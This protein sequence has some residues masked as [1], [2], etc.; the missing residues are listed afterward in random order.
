M[1]SYI[2]K[3]CQLFSI[4]TLFLL[5]GLF[6]QPA[7]AQCDFI[8]NITGIV[9]GTLPVGD[10]ANPL[11]YTQVYVLVDNQGNIFATNPTPN[12][13]LVPAGFYQL[14]AVNYD[15]AEVLT[16]LPMLAIGQPWFNLEVYGND[17][18]NNCLDYSLPYGS[19]CP[20]VVCDEMTICEVDTLNILALNY[21]TSAHSQTYCLVCNDIVVAMETGGLF[22]LQDYT[23]AAAGANCQ[24]F[25]LNFNTNDGNPISLGSNWTT[26]TDAEC[27]SSCIDFVGMSLDITGITQPSGN[28]VSTTVDWWNTSGCIGAQNATNGGLTFLEV[29]DN[30]CVPSYNPSPI[31]ARPMGGGDDLQQYAD[32]RTSQGRFACSGGMDLTQ[33]PIFY[34]VECATTGPSILNVLVS[35]TGLGITGV[36]AALYGPVNAACPTFS[37][38]SFVDC[39]DVGTN[40]ISGLPLGNLT[41]TTTG[42]PGEVYLVIVDTEG[43][44]QFT[45]SSAIILLNTKLVNFDGIKNGENNVLSWE[46][47]DEKEVDRYVLERSN[48]GIDFAVLSETVALNNGNPTMYY[49]YTDLLPGVGVRYYRLKSI[50]MDG[51]FEYSNVVVLSRGEENLGGV[52]VY[53]NPTKGTFFVEFDADVATKLTYKIQDIIG[54]TV[55]EGVLKTDLGLNKIELDLEGFPSATYVVALTLNGQRVQRKLIKQ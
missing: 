14:Y 53:P 15:N 54:Q 55:K 40:A 34:T 24:L 9:Q 46:I 38:G 47:Q 6:S 1:T 4:G 16:V 52:A 48:N 8:N 29:V 33:Q 32:V 11:L 17:D 7:T 5:C 50:A 12:F 31:N 49:D 3:H 20:I 27:A 39:N 10:A 26:T 19:G 37:G 35:S 23:A 21:N 44:D 13:L 41:L 30:T 18:V 28:G 25:G 45:I 36:Q 51:S 2:T 22:P 43:A 42:N